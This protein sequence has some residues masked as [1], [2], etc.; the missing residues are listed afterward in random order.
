MTIAKQEYQKKKEPAFKVEAEIIRQSNESQRVGP[1]LENARYGYI[2]DPAVQLMGRNGGYWTAG[3]GGMHFG[4]QNNALHGN[5][6]G[7]GMLN[8]LNHQAVSNI[9]IGI[10]GYTGAANYT[11][12][13]GNGLAHYPTNDLYN[14]FPWTQMYYWY[15]AK[16]VSYA[17]QIV[18]IPKAMPK[19]SETTGEELRIFI[20]DA[21]ASLPVADRETNES[22]TK[23]FS[24]HFADYDFDELQFLNHT[25]KLQATQHGIE[26][27]TTLGSGYFEVP[28]PASYWAA[29]NAAGYKMVVSINAEWLNAVARH[30]TAD[31]FGGNALPV[32]TNV[33][34]AGGQTLPSFPNAN[35]FSIF[36]LGIR[37]Y[38]ELG[39]S[40]VE[41]APYYAPRIHITDDV[42]FTPGTYVQYADSFIDINEPLFITRVEYAY[43]NK[44][45]SSTKFNL[46]RE[47]GRMAE[48][49]EGYLATNP[50]EDTG[51][52]GGGVG[53][54]GGGQNTPPAGGGG[55]GGREGD[56]T[57]I[58]PT[59][60]N[61]PFGYT[62]GQVGTQFSNSTPP[63][64][65]GGGGDLGTV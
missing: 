37:E 30:K 65:G 7:F 29:G 46:E 24:I 32:Q 6:S 16:S 63:L 55:T 57:Y 18:H 1:M 26:T 50:L 13:Y 42:N 53:G 2:A 35:E 19:V 60:D 54:G 33:I 64:Q 34:P 9:G 11:T 47:S 8:L 61:F 51:A 14:M 27:I 40:A 59:N 12:A 41:R 45:L 10:G 48:G 28:I 56:D 36:P 17:V 5:I 15:G 21:A 49:L 23:K 22:N 38:P 31:K 39:T 3:R 43:S 52:S 4:G 62:G 20:S 25:P 44:R 58:P